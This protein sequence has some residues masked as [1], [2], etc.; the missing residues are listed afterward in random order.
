MRLKRPS[1]ST[2]HRGIDIIDMMRRRLALPVAEH[3]DEV[4]NTHHF[5]GHHRV[6]YDCGHSRLVEGHDE[7]PT[8]CGSCRHPM[9]VSLD[10]ATYDAVVVPNRDAIRATLRRAATELREAASAPKAYVDPG[11]RFR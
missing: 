6:T 7:A 4:V 8:W 1:A 9:L 11:I 5:K 2:R 10:E 3:L